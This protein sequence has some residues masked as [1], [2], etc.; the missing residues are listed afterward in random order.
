MNIML[1]HRKAILIDDTYNVHCTRC[2]FS[3][4]EMWYSIRVF[5]YWNPSTY[6]SVRRRTEYRYTTSTHAPSKS[7]VSIFNSVVLMVIIYNVRSVLRTGR[8]IFKYLEHS[9]NSGSSCANGLGSLRKTQLVNISLIIYTRC[10]AKYNKLAA[11]SIRK[12]RLYGFASCS[13]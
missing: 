3:N 2:S 9:C 7:Q 1:M 10:L 12:S 13:I 8:C 11:H 4:I 6:I 5:G